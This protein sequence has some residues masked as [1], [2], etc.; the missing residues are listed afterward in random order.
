M[1]RIHYII[2]LVYLFPYFVF[3]QNQWETLLSKEQFTLKGY[4]LNYRLYKPA[5]INDPGRPLVIFLHGAGE[6]GNDNKT[7]LLHGVSHFMTDSIRQ[8][9]QFEMLVPQCPESERWVETDWTK[10]S[11]VMSPHPSLIM[12]CLFELIDS[13]IVADSIDPDRIYVTG[14]SM[15]GF[16]TWDVLQRKPQL[17][18]AGVAVCGGG[19]EKQAAQLIDIP[20]RI[21][22][23]KLDHLVI[24]AR[25]INMF[26]AIKSSGGNKVE[27]TLFPN[28]GHLCW[29]AVYSNPELYRWLFMQKKNND[30]K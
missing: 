1:R 12:A 23:G 4:S 11:H 17:F 9:Y 30:D 5:Q 27:L 16:G 2:A 25:S 6:R 28:L 7:Q 24:P 29:E 8:K 14:L 26:N 3:A 10:P 21:F 20:I 13:L 19:D 18:A 22:H 15:G